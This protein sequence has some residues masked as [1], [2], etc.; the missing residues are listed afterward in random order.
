MADFPLTIGLLD[1]VNY[2]KYIKDFSL[3]LLRNAFWSIFVCDSPNR[4]LSAAYESEKRIMNSD[5][6]S[7]V[8]DSMLTIQACTDKEVPPDG[9]WSCFEHKVR[10][11]SFLF[12]RQIKLILFLTARVH[13]FHLSRYC[14]FAEEIISRRILMCSNQF[15][16]LLTGPYRWKSL[17]D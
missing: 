8:Y 15:E 7:A 9:S 11:Y 12:S 14:E 6:S 16:N 3:L 4:L 2:Y 10:N 17:V 1:V 13:S 5:T